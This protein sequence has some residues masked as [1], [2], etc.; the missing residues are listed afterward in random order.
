MLTPMG[1][2]RFT[3]LDVT[4]VLMFAL[5]QLAEPEDLAVSK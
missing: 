2:V 5:S 3:W 1:R 4:L